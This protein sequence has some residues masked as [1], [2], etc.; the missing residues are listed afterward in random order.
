M[1]SVLSFCFLEHEH[2]DESETFQIYFRNLKAT[3]EASDGRQY[4]V[5]CVFLCQKIVLLI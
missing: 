2:K 4:I 1:R 5:S 3:R